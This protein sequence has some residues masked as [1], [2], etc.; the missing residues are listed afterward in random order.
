VIDGDA[1]DVVNASGWGTSAGRVSY[2][3]ANYD[4]YNQ[5]LHAQLLI[6]ASVTQTVL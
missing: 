6:G 5:G 3:G 1:G 4:V 2:N